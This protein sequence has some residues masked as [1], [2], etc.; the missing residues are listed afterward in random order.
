M[1]CGVKHEVT[2]MSRSGG[3]TLIEMIVTLTILSILTLVAM[4]LAEGVM[5][6]GK[7][8]ALSE[9]LHDIRKALD[10][11][12]EA[13]DTGRITMASPSGYPLSLEILV[14]GVP[15]QHAPGQSLYFLRRIPR[16]PFCPEQILDEQ[17]WGLRAFNSPP[18]APAPGADVYDVH[19]NSDLVG[20]DGRPYSKW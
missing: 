14:A 17:C 18:E 19:S 2:R 11:Y 3:F 20:S 8:R 15:D 13:A 4:P 12:K 16:D 9:A 10:Q 7:E 6:T 5:R 1:K